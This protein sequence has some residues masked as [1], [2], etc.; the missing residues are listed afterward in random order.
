MKRK[1][2]TLLAAGAVSATAVAGGA[3]FASGDDN[4]QAEVQAF[5]GATQDITAAIS[6]AEAASSGTAVA[7]EFDDKNGTGLYEVDTIA[8]GKQISVQID[9]SSGQVIKTEDE[10][11]I[12]NADSDDI[13]DPA[14]LG[15]PLPQLIAMAEQNGS[16][17]VMSID[18]E[19]K[20]G[21]PGVIEVELA[22][23]DGTTQ[24]FA[25]AADGTMTPVVDGH[26]EDGEDHD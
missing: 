24:E 17:K 9:A 25:M 3:A 18:Y 15:A 12:A 11:D 4:D 22:N 16:G 14:Q 26:G 19:V 2:M 20:D 6:A 1:L 10:G 5:L 8:N 23:T 21:Q 7:A 13:T